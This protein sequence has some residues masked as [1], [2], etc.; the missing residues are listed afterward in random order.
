VKEI[1]MAK[2]VVEFIISLHTQT[3]RKFIF[4]SARW[5]PSQEPS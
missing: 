2:L 3:A 1:R 5:L 4:R